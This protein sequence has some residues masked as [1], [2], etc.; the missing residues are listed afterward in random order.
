MSA[1]R[2]NI[3][4]DGWD[5][6]YTED[7]IERATIGETELAYGKLAARCVVCSVEPSTGRKL[8]QEPLR[9]LAMYR[10]DKLGGGL[11]NQARGAAPR[12]A[13]RG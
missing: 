11:W 5:E 13:A 7:R 3:V 2:A 4:V 1:F 6:P 10:R 8:G 9:T 12:P